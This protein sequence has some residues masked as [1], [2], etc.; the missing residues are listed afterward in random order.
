M[1]RKRRKCG[2][3]KRFV[4]RENIRS[5]SSDS[6]KR[7]CRRYPKNCSQSK[8][9]RLLHRT[10]EDSDEDLPFLTSDDD[11]SDSD[12]DD[13]DQQKQQPWQRVQ[14]VVQEQSELM[15]KAAQ[16][17][18]DFPDDVKVEYPRYRCNCCRKYFD[19]TAYRKVTCNNCL[20][21]VSVATA[22]QIVCTNYRN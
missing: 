14:N 12:T 9:L 16:V 11:S 2:K 18:I 1:G 19:L 22:V 6:K 4:P 17:K 5:R 15:H 3:P 7:A 21:C 13:D 10:Q 20:I 8:L